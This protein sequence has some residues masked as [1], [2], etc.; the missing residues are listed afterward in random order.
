MA[1]SKRRLG[2]L[3]AI[4]IGAIFLLTVF[5]A[6]TRDKL[7]S[8][9]TYSRNPNGYGAWYAFM[10]QRGTPVERWEKPVEQLLQLKRDRFP[11]T[12]VRVNSEL[13]MFPQLSPEENSWVEQGNK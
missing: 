11:A 8:G 9:S 5:A 6:P 13:Q 2:I 12:L 4:A 3:I 1:I 10:N 7:S